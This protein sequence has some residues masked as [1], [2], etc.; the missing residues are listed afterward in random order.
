M[1]IIAMYRNVIKHR[2]VVLGLSQL[3]RHECIYN[4]SKGGPSQRKQYLKSF[5]IQWFIATMRLTNPIFYPLDNF[6]S[7]A[8][9][10]DI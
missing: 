3:H 5:S 9:I 6:S 4:D 2:V 10:I 8:D 7:D 1:M